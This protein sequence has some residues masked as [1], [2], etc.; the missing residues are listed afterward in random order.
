MNHP[1]P[2]ISMNFRAAKLTVSAMAALLL[3]ACGGG[4]GGSDSSDPNLKNETLRITADENTVETFQLNGSIKA[5]SL[6]TVIDNPQVTASLSGDTI[7]INIGELTNDADARYTVQTSA[8]TRY[9]IDVDGLN[10]SATALVQQA[11]TLAE[12]SSAQALIA[13]DVRLMN[14]ML[15]VEYLAGQISSTEK[16]AIKVQVATSTSSLDNEISLTSQ[17]L[18]DYQNGDITDADL[19]LQ[20]DA[21]TAAVAEAGQAGEQALDNVTDTLTAIGITLPDDLEG[22]YPLEYVAGFDRYSRFMH[23]DFGTDDGN[24]GFS[25]SASYDFFNTV[26]SFAE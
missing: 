19:Q 20:V 21:T 6:T 11:T 16:D 25:F 4:G 12:L 2:E 3:T 14:V 7:S 17:A 8:N 26:F 18:N 13:D 23:P 10:T 9:T 1:N 5:G 24:G 22:S 15:E